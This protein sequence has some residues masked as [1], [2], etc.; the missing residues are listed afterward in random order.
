MP[1]LGQRR[2]FA[3]ILPD[4]YNFSVQDSSKACLNVVAGDMASSRIFVRGLP[5][6]MGEQ[7]F[8]KHFG[9]IG[10]VTDIRHFQQRRIGYV[11]FATSQDAEKAVKYFNKSFIRMSKIAVEIARPVEPNQSTAGGRTAIV[12]HPE[13]SP[14]VVD[15]GQSPT[16]TSSLKR[17]RPSSPS[18]GEVS[19]SQKANIDTRKDAEQRPEGHS[20]DSQAAQAPEAG[21]Q[22]GSLSE[23]EGHEQNHAESSEKAAVNH[24]NQNSD[25]DWL[26]SRTSRLLGL[27]DDD[28]Q[29][30]G[31]HVATIEA[32]AETPI[33]NV[34]PK[35]LNADAR[36]RTD[37]DEHD[38]E[39]ANVDATLGIAV[40]ADEQK[41]RESKRLYLRN[42][43]Y[44]V[45]E[46]SLRRS[47]QD[48]ATL[49]EV[50]PYHLYLPVLS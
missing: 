39:P 35:A 24:E 49:D 7:D 21:L 12:N 6:T 36:P 27:D 2:Q 11:G 20:L 15:N 9:V 26:R 31:E 30:G 33:D 8:K 13:S 34:V 47:F 44:E 46:D 40:D 1:R 41:I 4:F 14:L 25:A 29:E 22:G 48:F 17:K 50:S 18:S 37:E 32:R 43:S 23:A 19:K 38:G 28:D 5:P 45:N 10:S 3:K 42:L 16:V